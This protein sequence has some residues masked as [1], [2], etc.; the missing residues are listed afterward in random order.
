MHGQ[1][2]FAP[3]ARRL[4]LACRFYVNHL[5]DYEHRLAKAAKVLD[6]NT[7]DLV[8]AMT[9]A[10]EKRAC[11]A[12]QQA[13]G[14]H[15]GRIIGLIPFYPGGVGNHNE[16]GNAHSISSSATKASWLRVVVCS[17]AEYM[18]T[19]VIGTCSAEHEALAQA[20]LAELP[21]VHPFRFKV[22]LFACDKPMHLPYILLRHAQKHLGAAIE[23]RK[24]H[25]VLE[26]FATDKKLP[27]S[28]KAHDR[29]LLGP[30]ARGAAAAAAAN[31]TLAGSSSS[32]SVSGGSAAKKGRSAGG[33]R[34]A[35][36][37]TPA[38][39]AAAKT[40]IAGHGGGDEEDHHH[41][42][43]PYA[44]EGMPGEESDVPPKAWAAA[45]FV[46]F[47]E[48]DNALHVASPEVFDM[49]V[50]AMH[51]PMGYVSPNRMNKQPGGDPDDA[52][53]KSFVINGQNACGRLP[54]NGGD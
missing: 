40:T 6:Q 4:L 13:R 41:K 8:A 23:E 51:G 42:T 38:K 5:S 22:R 10:E 24:K 12:E 34:L 28:A 53:D 35:A 48:M 31:A 49:L 15:H 30:T 20:A 43:S 19:I 46:Y 37:K 7:V 39:A 18:A 27:S 9:N 25:G 29:R 47:T 44:P 52:S 2:P 14:S 21:F 11:L 26:A 1:L 50:N 17:L 32:G 3:S 54:V 45:Q 16:T 36:A 33:R